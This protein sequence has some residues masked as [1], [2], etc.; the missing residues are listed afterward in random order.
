MITKTSVLRCVLL[1]IL[2]AG[3]T[4]ALH[5]QDEPLLER[6]Q[7]QFQSEH[8]RL[9]MLTQVVGT[10]QFDAD[11]AVNG[12][13]IGAARLSARGR[14][15][16]GFNYLLQTEFV[17]SPVLLDARLG[18]A[19]SET[20]SIS[21]GVYKAP[22]SA[23]QLIPAAN[24]DMINR[25]IV[26]SA[27]APGRQIGVSL[28]GYNPERTVMYSIGAFNG[29]GRSLG[30]NDNNSLLYAGRLAVYPSL[31]EGSLELGLNL[32]YSEDPGPAGGRTR[33]LF[34]GDARFQQE[35]LLLAGEV[36]YGDIDAAVVAGGERNPVGYQATAGYM[37]EPGVHQVLLRLD[38]FD[39]DL[40]A[41]DDVNFLIFGYNYW[42]TGAFELQVNF[43]APLFEGGRSAVLVNFQVSF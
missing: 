32:A 9:G 4:S 6:L 35:R 31:S 2:S 43:L 24:I 1:F 7:R 40:A 34:G 28:D 5:A 19:F 14:L 41:G 36:I 38:G 37:L 10:L 13:S 15:D 12:F 16:G 8:F 42:P 17:S 22:F 3:A 25:S 11:D 33:F 27:L 20:F 30:G 39:P 23:E 29:N 21:A 26:V 18:Y